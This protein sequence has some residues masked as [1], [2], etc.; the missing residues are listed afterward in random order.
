[1]IYGDF[2]DAV[3]GLGFVTLCDVWEY[4]TSLMAFVCMTPQ[5]SCIIMTYDFLVAKLSAH[6]WSHSAPWKKLIAPLSNSSAVGPSDHSDEPPCIPLWNVGLSERLAMQ[7]V[8][9]QWSSHP[10]CWVLSPLYLPIL[11][12][13]IYIY[14]M[15]TYMYIINIEP[16]K[17]A[18][19]VSQT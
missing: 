14:F 18:A 17:P 19:E 3:Y 11:D 4:W 1:M 13:Y 8:R 12:I 15:A 10:I 6:L 5:K 7:M 9:S 2:G 16:G